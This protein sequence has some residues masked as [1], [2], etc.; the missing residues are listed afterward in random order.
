MSIFVLS[1]NSKFYC[2]TIP[3]YQ[4]FADLL[5]HP[6]KYCKRPSLSQRLLR[7]EKWRPICSKTIDKQ[8][9]ANN[10]KDL[11]NFLDE[12]I[13]N[14]KKVSSFIEKDEVSKKLQSLTI[15]QNVT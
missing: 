5:Q 4:V 6:E 12:V 3:A 2:Y 9:I 15:L 13:F 7:K 11:K 1:D 10:N 14:H 8:V